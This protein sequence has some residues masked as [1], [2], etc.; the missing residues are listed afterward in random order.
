MRKTIFFLSCLVAN[1][2]FSITP[3]NALQLLIDGN[4]RYVA[5]QL[6][7]PNHSSD[8]REAIAAKQKPFAIIVGCSD[9]RVAPEI[10]FDQGLGDLFIVRVAGNVVGPVELDS[11]EYAA[12]H[13]G[14]SCLLIL[15]HEACGAVTAV[16]DGHT[17]DIEAIADLIG[18][19]IKGAKNVEE[20]V[21]DN[22]RSIVQHLKKTPV[23]KKLIAK[24]KI[25]CIGGYYELGSGNVEILK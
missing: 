17:Q 13:L 23:L 9:S 25:N 22:V 11:I 1:L 24:K 7:R 16:L 19:A 4:H 18:P 6:M 8:R 15:G 14:C 20:A 5:D 3:S 2:G 21:K 10:I 12:D